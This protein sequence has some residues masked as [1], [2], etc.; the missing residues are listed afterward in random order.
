MFDIMPP[1]SRGKVRREKPIEDITEEPAGE[2][3]MSPIAEESADT[4]DSF[5][6]KLAS[7]KKSAPADWEPANRSQAVRKLVLIVSVAAVIGIGT[8]F[9]GIAVSRARVTLIADRAFSPFSFEAT[10]DTKTQSPDVAGRRLPLQLLKKTVGLTKEYPATGRGTVNAMAHG[11]VTLYN[12]YSD[13]SQILIANTRL[14]SSDGKIFRLTSRV[15]I[16]GNGSVSA[17][18]VADKPGPDYNIGPTRFTIPAFRE[19]GLTERYQKIYAESKAAFRGGASG[20]TKLV[21]EEDI[22]TAQAAL[23]QEALDALQK[24]IRQALPEGFVMLEQGS[25]RFIANSISANAKAGDAAESFTV[26]INATIEALAFDERHVEELARQELKNDELLASLPDADF[27]FAYTPVRPADFSL[28]T[29]VLKVDGSLN[30]A[31]SVNIAKIKQS[32]AGKREADV[33]R[34]LIAIPG[35]Q[36]ARVTLWPFWIRRIPQSLDRIEIRIE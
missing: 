36:E 34:E 23:S 22:R 29:L 24:E 32:L 25:M 13:A 1:E 15:V 31:K 9:A 6:H 7:E 20:T 10:F 8:W 27:E 17:E 4:T 5:L 35:I 33:Q 16:P 19:Q 21:T 12:T 3:A 14:Q 11:Q 18:V 2:E 26:T 28:G 30:I